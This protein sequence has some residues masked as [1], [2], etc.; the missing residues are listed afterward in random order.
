MHDHVELQA[1]MCITQIVTT[2]TKAKETFA[3]L[4]VPDSRL[5]STI[6]VERYEPLY[7]YPS[8]ISTLLEN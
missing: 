4:H 2:T 5:E 8:I 7:Y 1:Y 6:T 3:V